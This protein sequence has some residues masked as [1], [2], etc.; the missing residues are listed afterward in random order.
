MPS[1]LHACS[2]TP[3]FHTLTLRAFSESFRPLYLQH[4][5]ILSR[6]NASSELEHFIPIYLRTGYVKRNSSPLDL[7]TFTPRVQ[8]DSSRFI[9]PYLASACLQRHSSTSYLHTFALKTYT[10]TPIL[11]LHTFTLPRVR[12]NTSTAL[13]R[14]WLFVERLTKTTGYTHECRLEQTNHSL[15]HSA[16]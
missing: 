9:L 14:D 16:G 1:H 7:H 6:L 15:L 3:A 4:T 8:P 5:S 11:Q 2:E 13:S 12:F 10:A